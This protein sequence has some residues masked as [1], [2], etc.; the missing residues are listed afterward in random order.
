[1]RTK[2]CRNRARAT[3]WAAV[4]GVV[5]TCAVPAC[6]F[7]ELRVPQWSWPWNRPQVIESQYQVP[8]RMAIVWTPDILTLPGKPPTR[9]F[10][11][12]IYFYNHQGQAIP[13]D[14]QLVVYGFD[15]SDPEVAST[16][17]HKKFVFTPEQFTKH[18]SPTELGASYS[19][20]IPWDSNDNRQKSISLLPVFTSVSGHR[21]VGEQ[22]MN[23]LRGQT[24]ETVIRRDSW[25]QNYEARRKAAIAGFE[26]VSEIANDNAPN[27]AAPQAKPEARIRTS[28]IPLTPSL[29]RT[30]QENPPPVPSS[31]LTTGPA[32]PNSQGTPSLPA[33]GVPALPHTGVSTL[34]PTGVPGLPPM[35]ATNLPPPGVVAPSV[36]IAGPPQDPREVVP[37][38]QPAPEARSSR[39]RFR[40]P[41]VPR[42][43]EPRVHVP[44]SR[45]LEAQGSN[46]RP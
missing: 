28:T 29:S 8:T 37:T 43:P 20:W 34:P 15:D 46:P 9:G 41:D 22:T 44:W 12:R 6:S 30:L 32:A 45:N 13:V 24:D 11:G 3:R 4:L 14:G 19:V 1:M 17:P 36:A 25:R 16:V 5:A 26:Q 23:V 35:G 42:V 40:A 38:G 7:N 31:P 21:I 2:I 18:F 10:G 27:P 33:T 39:S